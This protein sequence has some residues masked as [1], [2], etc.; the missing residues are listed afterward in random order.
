MG[1]LLEE[2]WLVEAALA[3][4]VAGGGGGEGSFARDGGGGALG[5]LTGGGKGGAGSVDGGGGGAS[6]VEGP[7]VGGGGIPV[8]LCDAAP[9]RCCQIPG[10]LA[11]A[12]GDTSALFPIGP[13]STEEAVTFTSLDDISPSNGSGRI[14]W[15][16]TS[17]L[18]S[19]CRP[20][21]NNRNS[22]R[23]LLAESW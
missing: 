6:S 14:W 7:V 12:A 15:G 16:S 22:S 3:S 20:L 19:R 8:V 23:S 4:V 5:S 10:T 1:P 2:D 17:K 21:L 13:T 9:S 18:I 11:T